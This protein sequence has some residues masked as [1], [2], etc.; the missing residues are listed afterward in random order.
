MG[1]LQ[2][3]EARKWTLGY[4]VGRLTGDALGI[5]AGGWSFLAGSG[6]EA[7]GMAISVGSS[8]FL[9]AVG[10]PISAGG[11]ALATAGTAVATKSAAGFMADASHSTTKSQNQ[12]SIAN[13]NN[14]VKTGGKSR[15]KPEE[16]GIPNSS[17]IIRRKDGKI[18]KYT[19]FNEDGT[20]EKEVRLYGKPHGDI[21]RPNVKYP[22]YNVNPKTGKKYFNGYKYRPAKTDEI[23][24]DYVKE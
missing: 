14:K 23:P 3:K 15:S 12:S 17:K 10:V 20:L 8:G 5:I 22:N 1:M 9:A 4:K 19:T 16:C 24:R 7:G 21:P 2:P 11:L 13:D 18:Y 6:M